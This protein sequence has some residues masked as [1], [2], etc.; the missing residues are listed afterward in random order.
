MHLDAHGN[1][2]IFGAFTDTSAMR[3][4]LKIEK[5]RADTAVRT[6]QLQLEFLDM[7][8]CL[9]HNNVTLTNRQ[10]T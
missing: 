2:Y 5:E 7:I 4:A 8:V 9:L 10:G 1:R 3:Y 6:K